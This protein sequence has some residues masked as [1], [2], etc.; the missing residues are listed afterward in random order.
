MCQ[1]SVPRADDP[2][3]CTL[4]RRLAPPL[5]DV[6]IGG[7]VETVAADPLGIE[8]VRDSVT[9]RDIAVTAVEGG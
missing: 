1:H 4:R 3:I 8:F 2:A 6:F 5:R 7:A 9:I